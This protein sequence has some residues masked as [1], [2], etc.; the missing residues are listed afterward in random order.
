MNQYNRKR[1][2]QTKIKYDPVEINFHDDNRNLITSLWYDYYT[3]YYNDANKPD[4]RF[5][6]QNSNPIK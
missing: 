4:V 3:Y 5:T 1:I 2:V 6:N